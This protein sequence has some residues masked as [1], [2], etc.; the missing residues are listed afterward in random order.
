MPKYE[1][2]TSRNKSYVEK[3]VYNTISRPS[4]MIPNTHWHLRDWQMPILSWHG[5]NGILEPK[6]TE[7]EESMHIKHSP[8][9]ITLLKLTLHWGG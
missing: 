2:I 1:F 3:E 4:N 9:I 8:S 6:G 7:K 5:G